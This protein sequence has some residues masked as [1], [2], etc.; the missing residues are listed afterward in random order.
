[1]SGFG[2]YSSTAL[3][4]ISGRSKPMLRDYKYLSFCTVLLPV[5][6]SFCA[7]F[8]SVNCSANYRNFGVQQTIR[9][10][11]ES[12]SVRLLF[13]PSLRPCAVNV[14]MRSGWRCVS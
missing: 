13:M 12:G 2:I 10:V 9:D 7:I 5:L 6:K 14:K 8:L 4:A 11:Q 1:M 3:G